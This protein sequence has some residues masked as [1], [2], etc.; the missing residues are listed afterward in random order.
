MTLPVSVEAEQSVLGGILLD[1]AVY[2]QVA[3]WLEP[4]D[5][6][7][8]D[9][10]AAFAAIGDLLGQDPPVAVDAI[11]LAEVLGDDWAG[12]LYELAR[13]TPSAANTSAYGEI[14]R[15]KANLRRVIEAGAKMVETGHKPEGKTSR[16]I[17]AEGAHALLNLAGAPRARGPIGMK[18]IG[19]AW[20]TQLQARYEAGGTMLGMP[21][22][23]REFNALTSG[24]QDGH[25]IILAGRPSMGKSA[26]AFNLAVALG[27]QSKRGMIFSF[28]MPSPSIFSRMVGIVSR[29]PLEWMRSF[30]GDHWGSINIGIKQLRDM[31]MVIDDTAGL[32]VD[33]VIARAKREHIKSPLRYLI[34]DHLH[35]MPLPG[36]TRETVEIGDITRKLKGLANTLGIP[37]ILLSQLN[38]SLE[39]RT[40]KRPVMADLRESGNIEQDADIIIFCYRDDYYA[41]MDNRLSAHPG[42]IELIIAKQR[43]GRPG[44]V[45]CDFLGEY[46]AVVDTDYRPQLEEQHAKPSRGIKKGKDY[47][48]AD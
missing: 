5:F 16:D 2:A 46:G 15:E 10:Q 40:N 43:D 41:Q 6:S 44:K 27:L 45:W 36:K 18:E 25:L 38:R 11:T 37:V 19:K 22:P 30:D 4:G 14:V 9:H 28:E 7:R 1:N 26:V 20:W 17:A 39:T 42:T 32:T 31:P 34:I 24:L 33:Q 23:W 48:H 21:T 29:V 35:L 13:T 12:Y 3:G 8:A 47:S